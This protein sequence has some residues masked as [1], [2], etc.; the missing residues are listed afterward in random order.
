MTY[1]N[2]L[3]I[4]LSFETL[5]ANG[6]CLTYDQFLD[7]EK[8]NYAH[9]LKHEYHKQHPTSYPIIETTAKL[10]TTKYDKI[11]H[12]FSNGVLICNFF[13]TE[14]KDNTTLK[15][16]LK[17]LEIRKL[18]V[19]K[20]YDL[21]NFINNI[22]ATDYM[23]KLSKYAQNFYN[24][25]DNIKI[26]QL[27]P[28][29]DFVSECFANGNILLSASKD[30]NINPDFR[31]IVALFADGRYYISDEP[32][33]KEAIIRAVEKNQYDEFVFLERVY[34]PKEYIKALYKEAE[35]YDWYISP[36]IQKQKN[37]LSSEET[38]KMNQFIENLF[39][40]RKCLS[41]TKL[42]YTT[43]LSNLTFSLEPDIDRFALFSD[44]LVLFSDKSKQIATSYTF[45]DMQET[46][47]KQGLELRLEIVPDYY[48]TAIYE[49]L[50]KYQRGATD[51]YMEM[52]KELA[53]KIK[54]EL[55]IAHYIA[56]DV[57]SIILGWKNFQ[58]IVIENEAHARQ[59]IEATKRKQK[60]LNKETYKREYERF[61]RSN[62]NV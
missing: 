45:E 13:H 49:A 42:E 14:N 28:I 32:N 39:S 30:E 61:I 35:K 9:N 25:K 21:S 33:K 59:L 19:N 51:I 3:P 48:I 29:K 41:T 20:I 23:E 37:Q 11:F 54:K 12:Y 60:F 57:A 8:Y 24:Y 36:Q 18:P 26:T 31:N 5:F 16:I 53:K 17:M 43:K 56:L 2:S 50:P 44:G 15:R 27:P 58:S 40:T 7:L 52:L 34:I 6:T 62:N 38:A 22:W 55:K 46:F 10:N 47:K 4:E 1:T